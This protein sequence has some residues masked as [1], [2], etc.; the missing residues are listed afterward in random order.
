MGHIRLFIRAILFL[1]LTVVIAPAYMAIILISF[2]WRRPLGQRMA[3]VYFRIFLF[4]FGV[5]ATPVGGPAISTSK[6]RGVIIVSNHVSFLDIFVLSALFQ[7]TFVSKK[8][9]IN[10]PFFGQFAWLMG[11]IFLKRESPRERYRLIKTIADEAPGQRVA[12]FP[13]G[14]TS[15]ADGWLHFN[16]GI[17]KAVEINPSVVLQPV[18][19]AYGNENDIAW[20]GVPLLENAFRVFRRSRI[21]VKVFV[22][23]PVTIDDY[24]GRTTS[25]VCDSVEQMV[26]RPLR[27]RG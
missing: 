19:L 10:Y 3:A 26:F 8:E 22:H 6:D 14:T 18:T 5:H 27:D 24:R 25:E 1:T 23:G 21:D 13:Q 17:F 16:R 7:T 15:T 12:V 11:V 2:P 4:I 9:V 20:I